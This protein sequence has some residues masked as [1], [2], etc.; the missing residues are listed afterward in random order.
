MAE[1]SSSGGTSIASAPARSDDL[2]WAHGQVVVGAKNTSICVY[3]NKRI[4]GG[5]TRLKYHLAG[6]KGQV[7]P[8]KRVPPDVQWQMNQL[9]ED[10]T[11]E[12]DKR[13]RVRAYIGNSQSISNDEVKRVMM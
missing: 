7:E 12:K 9:I 3:C 4:G 5:I 1:N 11:V 6:I 13:K 2:A 8:C 10:L